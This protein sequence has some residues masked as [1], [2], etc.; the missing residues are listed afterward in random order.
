MTPPR[1]AAPSSPEKRLIVAGL[2]TAT[3]SGGV[4]LMDRERLLGVISHWGGRAHSRRILSALQ[5]LLAEQGLAPGDLAA[6]AVSIGPG[7]FTGVRV[8]LAAAQA[9]AWGAGIPLYAAPTL[10]ALALRARGVD[11]EGRPAAADALICPTLDARRGEYYYALLAP[12][13]AGNAGADASA[14]GG[15]AT[16]TSC[17]F[18]NPMVSGAVAPAADF[19]EVIAAALPPGGAAEV[20]FCGEGA[21]RSREAL[22]RRLGERARFAP[23]HRSGAGPEEIAWFGLRRLLAGAPPEDPR[24]LR[25]VY[26][27]PPDV[28]L[29]PG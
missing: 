18:W 27:R 6:V 7:S 19:A 22:R 10:E 21:L 11:A 28:R 26:L 13:E 1:A 25:P 29:P 4:A 8:G 5:T 15:A 17:E 9:L 24:A 3:P 2:E 14:A 16:N 23:P 20:L 12:R